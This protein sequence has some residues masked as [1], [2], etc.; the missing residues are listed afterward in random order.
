MGDLTLRAHRPA[1]LEALAAMNRALIEDQGSRDI[2][3]V[4]ALRRRFDRFIEE[5]RRIDVFERDGAL[6][7]FASHAEE[8]TQA[9]PEG[10][11]VHLHQFYI[12]RAHRRRGIGR[13]AFQLLAAHR[14]PP[15]ARV[16][17]SVLE[18]NPA[19]RRFWSDLGF[20]PYAVTMETFLPAERAGA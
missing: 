19:G 16:V 8:D 20:E 11:H 7:G 3:D 2:M 6:V 15:G 14:W 17:I 10:R 18:S 5:G 1:D 4:V 9:A 12:E 13:E